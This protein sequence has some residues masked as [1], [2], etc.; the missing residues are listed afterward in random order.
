MSGNGTETTKYVFARIVLK[1]R[2]D[3]GH[4][5]VATIVGRGK[6]KA[7]SQAYIGKT[8]VCEHVFVKIVC[9]AVSAEESVV[10]PKMRRLSQNMNGHTQDGHTIHKVRVRIA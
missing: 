7:P 2:G 3:Q 9:F 5:F 4:P 6:V 10:W 8:G 1:Q